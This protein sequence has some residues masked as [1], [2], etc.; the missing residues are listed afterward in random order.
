V[1]PAA[2]IERCTA[3]QA[4]LAATLMALSDEDVRRPCLLPGWTV[5]HV[6]THLARNADSHVRILE[7]AA[8][9]DVVDQYP[10]GD[11]QRDG[12]IKAGAGR[13]AAALVADLAEAAGRLQAVWAAISEDTWQTGEGRMRS[14]MW[15]VATLPFLRWREVEVHHVDLGLGYTFSDWPD[16]YVDAELPRVLADLPRRL[17][18]GTGL[19]LRATDTGE[20]WTVSVPEGLVGEVEVVGE[21]RWLLAWLIGRIP[22]PTLPQL[23]PVW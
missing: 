12:D 22:H 2:D 7:A 9:G 19:A 16:S 10:G 21:R 6:I 20:A 15:P 4:R 17:P 8:R 14:G 1:R 11:E 13:P 3:A 23:G 5:G 18:P